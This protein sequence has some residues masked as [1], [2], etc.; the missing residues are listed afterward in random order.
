MIIVII[1]TYN[2]YNICIY[3]Y[4]YT[5]TY[6]LIKLEWEAI[7]SLAGDRCIVIKK[8]DKGSCVVV[9]NRLDYLMEAEKTT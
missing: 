1:C 7:R 2:I 4:T 3:I 6:I 5:Y 8:A 9:F